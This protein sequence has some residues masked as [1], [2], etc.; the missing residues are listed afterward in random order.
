MQTL[1]C[2]LGLPETVPLQYVGLAVDS[3]HWIHAKEIFE[4]KHTSA[5]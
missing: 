1:E 5:L 4:F 3:Y 2:F